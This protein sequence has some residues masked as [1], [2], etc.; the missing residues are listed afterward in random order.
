VAAERSTATAVGGGAMTS[1]WW[2]WR[3]TMAAATTS[4]AKMSPQRLKARFEVM[5]VAAIS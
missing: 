3:L 4:S 1:A 5:M 2:T